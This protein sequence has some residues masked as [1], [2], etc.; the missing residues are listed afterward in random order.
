MEFWLQYVTV[1]FYNQ[2]SQIPTSDANYHILESN[3]NMYNRILNQAIRK[4]KRYNF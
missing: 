4:A 2:K 1:M 3:L